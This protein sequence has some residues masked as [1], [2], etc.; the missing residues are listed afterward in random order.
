MAMIVQAP[1][2]ILRASI[3]R[4]RGTD[5]S[6]DVHHRQVAYRTNEA[7]RDDLDVQEDHLQHR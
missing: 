2:T 1:D 3:L 6:W 4:Y 5:Q 7:S